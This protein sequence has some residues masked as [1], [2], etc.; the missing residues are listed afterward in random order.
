MA[1]VEG[2]I[3]EGD[4]PPRVFLAKSAESNEKKGV[5]IFGSAKE[6]ASG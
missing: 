4:T 6:C 3:G 5:A 2:G 1:F